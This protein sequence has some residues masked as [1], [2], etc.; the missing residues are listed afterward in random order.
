MSTEITAA[1]ILSGG[2]IV[3]LAALTYVWVQNYRRFKTPLVAG[4]LAFS[5]VLALE[6]AV[7]IYFFFSSGMFYASDSIVQQVVALLRA[8]QFIALVFLASVTL[9]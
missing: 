8:L 6:N 9:R 4:L 7:A 1:A 2:N 3:L 5:V